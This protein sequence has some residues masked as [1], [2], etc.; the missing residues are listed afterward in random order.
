MRTFRLGYCDCAKTAGATSA[1]AA[2]DK[3][4]S[5]K[6]P[7]SIPEQIAQRFGEIVLAWIRLKPGE[8][9]TAEEI[10]AF[11]GGQIARFKIP[12]SIRFVESFPTTLSGKIQKFRMREI[13]IREQGL[14]EVARRGTA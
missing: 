10:R 8:A 9:A 12:E 5:Q 14:E 11:C 4:P 3:P 6:P 1:A 2:A 13:E 7:P